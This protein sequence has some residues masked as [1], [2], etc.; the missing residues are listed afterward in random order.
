MVC[1][2]L[3]LLFRRVLH[4]LMVACR[5]MIFD[6][7]SGIIMVLDCSL[8]LCFNLLDHLVVD[9]VVDL[10]HCFVEHQVSL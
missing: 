6:D 1:I 7:L 5:P 8:A 4:D 9:Q 3:P 2:L 10:E